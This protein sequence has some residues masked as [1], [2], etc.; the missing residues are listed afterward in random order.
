MWE[1]QSHCRWCHPRAGGTQWYTT[2]YWASHEKQARKQ[3]STMAS[4]WF[5]FQVSAWFHTLT[6]LSDGQWCECVSQIN[7]PPH[8]VWI[9]DF[10]HSN[11]NLAKT[12]SE[13]HN[14]SLLQTIWNTA[15]TAL[16][17]SLCFPMK[18]HNLVLHHLHFY[19]RC[20]FP[21]AHRTAALHTLSI[22]WIARW[23]YP[24]LS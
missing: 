6:S 17:D 21:S 9:C 11:R 16:R 10:Y 5:L 19:Q 13:T 23:K 12:L 14:V 18:L 3:Q 1:F 2:A 8:L 24:I 20:H 22:K 15:G 4:A 7:F